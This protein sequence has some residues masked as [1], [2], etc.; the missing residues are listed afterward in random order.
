MQ[1]KCP[2]C[3]KQVSWNQ[4]APYRPFCSKRCQLI[5]LGQWSN[6]EHTITETPQTSIDASVNDIDIEA[7]EEM[8]QATNTNDFFKS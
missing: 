3:S 1:V 5:D 4:S 2:N 6:E 7:I 8:I